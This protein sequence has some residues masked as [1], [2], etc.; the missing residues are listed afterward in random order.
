[1]SSIAGKVVFFTALFLLSLLPSLAFA[2]QPRAC[3]TKD[4][5]PPPGGLPATPP[6]EFD[7]PQIVHKQTSYFVKIFSDT[8]PKPGSRFDQCFRYEAENEGPLVVSWFYW[9]LANG[10]WIESMAK[11]ERHSRKVVRPVDDYPRVTAT[12]VFAFE[13]DPGNTRAWATVSRPKGTASS[14]KSASFETVVPDSIAGLSG[15]LQAHNL[16][17]RPL[18]AFYLKESGAKASTLEDVYS[19][20]RIKIALVSDASREGDQ[21]LVKTQIVASGEDSTEA[22]YFMPALRA[23]RSLEKPADTQTYE[24]FVSR[25]S[26]F[27]RSAMPYQSAWD[28]PLSMAANTVGDGTVY[29]ILHPIGVEFKG[30]HICILAA[31]YAPLPVSFRTDDCPSWFGAA[32]R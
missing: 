5:E 8:T 29:R 10:M 17:P 15:F 26:E 3:V 27:R 6:V 1:M 23:L 22:R 30:Q 25:Y 20:P 19:G 28:F 12:T 2:Q 14:D 31:S 11:G 32:P 21:I 4:E 9:E 18:T 7:K 24:Q 16:P 13:K